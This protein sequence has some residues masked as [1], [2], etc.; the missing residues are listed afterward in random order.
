MIA[1]SIVRKK[2]ALKKKLG[3]DFARGKGT[4]V[5]IH[6][7]EDELY[8]EFWDRPGMS[9]WFKAEFW[10]I[11]HNGI[12]VGLSI[13]YA[14]IAPDH[15]WAV[16]PFRRQ[17]EVQDKVKICL[18]GRIPFSHIVDYDLEGDEYYP[19]PHIYCRYPDGI[20]YEGFTG[21]LVDSSFKQRLDA[22]LKVTFEEIILGS[23]VKKTIH[24]DPL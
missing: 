2:L 1:S 17:D 15:R 14:V 20:P 12:E 7:D 4:E 19:G 9:N 16:V 22:T 21:E 13:E 23:N 6:C 3:R 10:G 11:Y 5:I 8:P 24:P 18:L